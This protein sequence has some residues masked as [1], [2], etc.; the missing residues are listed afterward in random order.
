MDGWKFATSSK[1]IP[2]P[3]PP[4]L[5]N[6]RESSHPGTPATPLC[7]RLDSRGHLR[8]PPRDKP[9]S[10]AP[11]RSAEQGAGGSSPALPLALGVLQGCTGQGPHETL[12]PCAWGA[13]RMPGTKTGRRGRA[14][15]RCV[16]GTQTDEE[17][18]EEE[19]GRRSFSADEALAALWFPVSAASSPGRAHWLRC[20]QVLPFKADFPWP[21][22]A[23][24]LPA[25]CVQRP[26]GGHRNARPGRWARMGDPCLLLP[27]IP[28]SPSRSA[29]REAMSPPL[30]IL[31]F[32]LQGAKPREEV[33][34]W[35]RGDAPCL[36]TQPG[37]R[38]PFLALVRAGHHSALGRG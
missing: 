31:F 36:V 28:S 22:A 23:R 18:E 19:E 7:G 12:S 27:A 4:L 10:P 29:G 35:L 11:L 32:F 34:V 6:P 33:W 3:C 21:A 24:E 5:A 14:A 1:A 38:K 30:F 17:E 2:P 8:T 26:L 20:S 37:R 9:A 15:S 13:G 25:R 16:V